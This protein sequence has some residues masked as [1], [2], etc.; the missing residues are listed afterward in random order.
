VDAAVRALE[1]G[2]LSRRYALAISDDRG[3]ALPTKP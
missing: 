1:E 3:I 2:T